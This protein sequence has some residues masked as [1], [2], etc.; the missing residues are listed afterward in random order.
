MSAVLGPKKGAQYDFA[1]AQ[2]IHVVSP[3]WLFETLRFGLPMKERCFPVG[4][5]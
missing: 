4:R 3:A 5:G 2:R 1:V